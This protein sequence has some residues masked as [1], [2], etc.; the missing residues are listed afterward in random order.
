MA[1]APSY[2]TFPK[3]HGRY[4]DR[5][6][7]SAH[8]YALGQAR[9]EMQFGE[10][11]SRQGQSDSLVRA[12]SELSAEWRP[13][14]KTCVNR[15]FTSPRPGTSARPASLSSPTRPAPQ[16]QSLFRSYGS[17]LPTSLT[18]ISL[19]TRGSL[20]WRPAADM[21]TKRRDTSTWPSSGFSRSEGKIRTPPQLRCSSRSKPYLPARG[22]QGTRTLIQKRKLFPDLPTASPGHFGL[23]RRTLLRGPELHAVPLPGSG[24]GTGFPFARRCSRASLEYL[25]L[26]P[27]SAPTAAPARLAPR[28]FCA[29]RSD[30]PTRQ[31][32]MAAPPKGRTAPLAADGRSCCLKQPTPFMASHKRRLRRLNSAFGS[33]HSASSAYQNLPT[34]H[35]DPKSRGFNVQAS[36]RSHPF[37]V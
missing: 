5:N 18:Y 3:R 35:S 17:N 1:W 23:P 28:P 31:D 10:M 29:H 13:K 26:P 4:E 15:S 25:L 11:L 34:W 21:V 6:L 8:H 36:Q 12:S 32:F 16:S 22:F 33:S 9:G 19:S 14:R 30:P 7:G 24:I 20:P 27:R 2:R 37:K